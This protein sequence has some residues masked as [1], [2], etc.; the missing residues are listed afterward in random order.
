MVKVESLKFSIQEISPDSEYLETIMRLGDANS[1]TLGSLPYGAFRRLAGEGF[2]LGCIASEV[3]CVGYLLYGISRRCSRVKLTHLCVAQE[4]RGKG[5]TKLL[6]QDLRKRTQHLYGILASC[7]RD[8]H[9]DRMWA[10]LG[11]VPLHE[12]PG[13][14]KYGSILTEWWFDYGHSD[15]LTTLAYQKTESRICV[16]IDAN[17]FFDLV[18]DEN[19]DEEGKESKVLIA[20][21]LKPELELCLTN[22]INNEISR[23]E[24]SK[25]RKKLREVTSKF[26]F[27][28]CSQEEFDQACK[29][30]RRFFPED[31][32]DS[33]HSDLRQ[34]ARVISSSLKTSFFVTRDKRLLGI[35]T[36]IYKE[37]N[38]LIIHPI[39]LIIRLDELRR[40]TEYQPERLV[41]TDIEE[42][43]IHSGD[44][45]SIIDLFLDNPQGEK[46]SDFRKKIR[47]L[48]SNTEQFK[49]FT[50]GRQ[51]EKPI[52]LIVYDRSE[53]GELKIPVFRF[54]D[55]KLT[56]TVLRRCIFKCFSTAASEERQFTRISETY[57]ED[58]TIA[59]L[60]EDSFIKTEKGWLRANLAIMQN[61]ADISS[62]IFNICQ[63]SGKG[64]EKYFPFVE[65]LA[66]QE[67]LSKTELMADIERILYPAKIAD[68]EIPTFII[69]IQSWFAK[70]LFDKELASEVLWG[71]KEEIA[72][73]REVVYYCAKRAM[74]APGRILWYVSKSGTG[75]NSSYTLKAIRACSRLDEIVIGKPKELYRR[76]RRL[77]VFNFKDILQIAD[78]DLNKDIMAVKFSDTELF[79]SPIILEDIKKMLGRNI[80]VQSSSKITTEN[81]KILYNIGTSNT[82]E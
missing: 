72:L 62:Y 35:E 61:A 4:W 54:R 52:A 25:K 19:F 60:Q 63:E 48:L 15:L 42:K 37:F 8:Y 36:D 6:I 39:D 45:D 3:G 79:K 46:K 69:P 47:Q 75:K 73:K 59:A 12:R 30:I 78:N 50:V 5:I 41:G 68:A 2:V 34:I 38:L 32:K 71:S 77:G 22:E 66:N 9:L 58:I 56:P 24:D 64:Y 18:D 23:N 11:F 10:Y 80:S 44:I 51:Q 26:T 49:C 31:M 28:P 82:I 14:S 33:D 16:A 1:K 57:L 76:F 7:R 74:Q 55:S 13:K 70:D 21:W 27:L 40:E 20:D 29:A 17:I 43:R 81:F 65:I 67:L 53:N